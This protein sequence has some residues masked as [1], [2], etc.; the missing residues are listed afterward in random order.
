MIPDLSI[1][2]PSLFVSSQAAS[3]ISGIRKK[4]CFEGDSVISNGVMSFVY[5][6]PITFSII[7]HQNNKKWEL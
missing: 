4:Y 6:I 1:L 2:S 5:L 3:Q 7:P